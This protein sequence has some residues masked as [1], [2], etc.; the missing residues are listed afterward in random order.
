VSWQDPLVTLNHLSW[1]L[2]GPFRWGGQLAVAAGMLCVA[3]SVRKSAGDAV[4][5][6]PVLYRHRRA[7]LL[8]A[9]VSCLL[10]WGFRAPTE[11][12]YLN[13]RMIGLAAV[14]LLP[15][16]PPGWFQ[17]RSARITLT[18]F[19][20]FLVLN[21]G[22]RAFGFAGEAEAPL[23]LLRLAQPRGLLAAL[24]FHNR[25]A[26]FA[27]GFRLTHY[28]PMYYTSRD[29]GVSTQFW[30]RYTPHL[31]VGYREGKRPA[32]PPD[33]SP[34]NV[35][36]GNLQDAEWIMTQQPTED[37]PAQMMASFEGVRSL[38]LA[39]GARLVS[40]EGGWCLYR[41]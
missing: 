35:Q 7:A 40:C 11:I 38:V 23:R 22:A 20:S 4:P 16:I 36:A 30:A 9:L 2:F 41:K 5:A 3:A 24:P 8:F 14:L 31:P 6:D 19:C 25:S 26:Y 10:P 1:T 15:L 39:Q 12:T 29:G 33:W 27:K 28:L 21:T 37:E 13:S 32:L 17:K 34:W 18:A